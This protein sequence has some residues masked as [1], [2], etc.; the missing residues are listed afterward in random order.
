[1]TS[2]IDPL[3]LTSAVEVLRRGGVVAY[4]TDTLFG[5][6]ADALN[7]AAVERVFEVKGRP[8][9]MPLPLIIGEPEQLEMV[10]DT[11]TGCAWKFASAFWPGGL[12]LVV[13]VGPNVPALV[14]ARGWKV[15]VR[16][17]DHPI[18]RELARQLGRPITGTSA[19]RSGGPDPSTAES[20]QNQ[21]HNTIDMI[22]RGGLAPAGRSSTVLDITGNQPKVLRHGAVSV[23]QLERIYGGPVG[24][25]E[26]MEQQS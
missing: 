12:T 13:P 9:G 6:G 24:T 26:T 22:L 1:M 16:L 2:Q 18:P 25:G 4:P 20:V 15:A 3:T 19:N 17:P 7:E 5:L 8:Q 11:V 21:F 23:E 10:A 14:T